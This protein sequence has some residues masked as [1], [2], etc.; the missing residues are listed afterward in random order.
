MCPECSDWWATRPFDAAFNEED[1]P[2]GSYFM[3]Q[4]RGHFECL[5]LGVIREIVFYAPKNT[6][7]LPVLI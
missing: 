3:E 1:Y 2:H 5:R 7:R 4:A 6:V